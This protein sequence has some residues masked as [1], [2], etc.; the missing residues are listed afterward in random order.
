LGMGPCQGTR[1][2]GP[3]AALFAKERGLG[4]AEAHRELLDFIAGRYR[5]KRPVLDGEQVAEEE[6]SRGSYLTVGNLDGTYA[7]D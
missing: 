2:A 6:L 1:C 4:S 7:S 3:A 5:G